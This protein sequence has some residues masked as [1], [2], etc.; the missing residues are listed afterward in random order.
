LAAADIDGSPAEIINHSC[1]VDNRCV[2]HHEITPTAEMVLE[3][4]NIAEREE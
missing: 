3:A 4:M 2:V 1:P